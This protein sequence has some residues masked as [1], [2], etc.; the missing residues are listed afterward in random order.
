MHT[1]SLRNMF[2]TCPPC[3][4]MPL[5]IQPLKKIRSHS[6]LQGLRD[7]LRNAAALSK[8]P[9]FSKGNIGLCLVTPHQQQKTLCFL[10]NSTS[11]AYPCPLQTKLGNKD[12]PWGR[13]GFKMLIPFYEAFSISLLQVQLISEGW[14]LNY[15]SQKLE[16]TLFKISV[17]LHWFLS[18]REWVHRLLVTYARLLWFWR[19][20]LADKQYSY[21]HMKTGGHHLV[22]KIDTQRLNHNYNVEI[23][24]FFLPLKTFKET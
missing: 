6:I 24:F 11:A 2:R 23:A 14:K 7:N 1:T 8:L 16:D 22:R 4:L 9:A 15:C 10:F 12:L 20:Q 3:H 17:S 21:W 19:P 18:K 13:E 5:W